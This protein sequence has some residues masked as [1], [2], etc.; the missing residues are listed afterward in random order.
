VRGTQEEQ[1]EGLHGRG[2]V[3]GTQRE[4]GEGLH[5]RERKGAA[6]GGRFLGR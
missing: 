1:R 4:Q 2:K 6:E 3:R 5:A